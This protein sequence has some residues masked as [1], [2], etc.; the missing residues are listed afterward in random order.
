[1]PAVK[2]MLSLDEVEAQTMFELPTRELMH[3]HSHSGKHVTGGTSATNSKTITA[4]DCSPS[5]S[6]S[7]T[8]VAPA[9]PTGVLG[10]LAAGLAIPINVSPSVAVFVN[11]GGCNQLVNNG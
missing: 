6:S 2:K 9:S 5:A 3:A 4:T 11:V 7:N 1:M 10:A 8:Q